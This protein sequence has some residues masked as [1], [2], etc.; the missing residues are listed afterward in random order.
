MAT[1]PTVQQN[2][3]VFATAFCCMALVLG[4]TYYLTQTN[5]HLDVQSIALAE[6]LSL[7]HI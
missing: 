2:T 7:I 1:K 6:H 3:G 5:Q 4:Y